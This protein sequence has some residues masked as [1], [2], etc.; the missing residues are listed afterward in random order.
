MVPRILHQVWLGD[1]PLPDEFAAYRESW[2]RHHPD[3]EHRLWTEEN[4]PDGLRRP[5]VYERLRVPAER[6]DILRLEVLWRHGGV[7]VD[8]DFECHRPLDPVIEGLEFFTAPLKPNG[9]VNNAFIGSVPGHPIL[10][11][12]LNELRPR[13]FHGYDKHG[14]GPRFLDT[15]LQDYPEATRLPAE[16]F[17]QTSPGQLAD[18]VATHHAAGSW[19]TVESYRN[20]VQ[21]AERRNF[22]LRGRI[23][24][25][26]RELEQVKAELDRAGTRGRRPLR[27][28]R[29]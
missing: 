12:A 6:S 16:L 23:E 15:L 19:K 21:L 27:G 1:R 22:E 8:T 29:R 20:A 9:W 24:E 17:Y 26:E 28:F 13:E 2:T 11:R 18:A 3:W 7:Y 10:D 25:L 4:L 5:E 14:T